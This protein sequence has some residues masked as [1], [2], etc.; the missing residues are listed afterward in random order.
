MITKQK[1]YEL[2]NKHNYLADIPFLFEQNIWEYDIKQANISALRAFDRIDEDNYRRLSLVPKMQREIEIGKMIRDDKSIGDIIKRGISEAKR[3]LI[4]SLVDTNKSIEILRIA[5][6][7]IYFINP[8]SP[9]IETDFHVT[10][11]TGNNILFKQKSHYN[12]Y[13]NFKVNNILVFIYNG[14]YDYYVEVKG[15]SDDKLELHRDYFIKFICDIITTYE[16]LGQPYAVI[17]INRFY[18]KYLNRQLPIEYYREFN[19]SSCYRI[20]T[21]SETFLLSSPPPDI[22]VIDI[23]FN[24]RLLRILYSYLL[25]A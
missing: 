4:K 8:Y 13:I 21:S 10:I 14:S 22:N 7:A 2:A 23:N 12:Y 16:K 25:S 19:S 20:I 3:E 18:E 24:L 17:E 1:I 11:S 5:N 9:T 15:I 6:D